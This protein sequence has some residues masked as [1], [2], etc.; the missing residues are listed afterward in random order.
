VITETRAASLESLRTRLE[1]IASGIRAEWGVYVKFLATG[2]EVRLNADAV[3]D[4]MSVIKIPLLLELLRQAEEG[5]VD[6]DE[7]I[8][9]ETRHKRFGTGVLQLLD[10]GLALSLRDA[11]TLMI[12][13]SDN[14]ATDLCFEA[15]GGPEAPNRLMR[16]LGLGSIEAL[17]TA[18]EWFSAL[19]SSM[20]PALGRLSPGELFATGYPE[21][22]R[23][24]LAA[25]RAAYHFDGGRWFGRATPGDLGRLL[26]RI[27]EG[28]AASPGVC[29]EVLRIMR[30][31]Q[32]RARIPKYLLGVSCANKT[33]DFDPFIAS[34]V[35]IIGLDEG[36][37][38]VVV[39]LTAG[40]RGIWANLEESVARMAEKVWERAVALEGSS[41]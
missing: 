19:A 18:F 38:A 30:L 1:R 13:Q 20:D 7:R 5:L 28:S 39:F 37:P 10:D 2:E 14:T 16:E 11:A 12:V 8:A 32:H 21:W 15:V 33:G 34:D 3:M 31:Q 23:D 25:A 26:E 40:H 24:E 35:G 6:L 27:R 17:G 4:T 41:G 29:E 9:L 36:S 22:T